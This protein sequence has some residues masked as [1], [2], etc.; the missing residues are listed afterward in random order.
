MKYFKGI[1]PFPFSFHNK[2]SGQEIVLFSLQMKTRII[3]P[4]R[5]YKVGNYSFTES[6][7]DTLP[8]KYIYLFH[9]R[10]IERIQKRSSRQNN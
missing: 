3:C 6:N 10:H 9:I 5:P 2:Y 1:F 7:N 8:L 4:L